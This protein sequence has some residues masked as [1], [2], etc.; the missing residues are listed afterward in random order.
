M[1]TQGVAVGITNK[2]PVGEV[3]GLIR[4]EQISFAKWP[5]SRVHNT[6]TTITIVTTTKELLVY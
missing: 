2:A 4:L 5:W 1:D 3:E 6:D